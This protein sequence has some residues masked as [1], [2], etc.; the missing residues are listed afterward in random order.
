MEEYLRKFKPKEPRAGL[1][2]EILKRAKSDLL[3]EGKDTAK[4]SFVERIWRSRV[5]WGTVAA[6][7]LILAGT[8]F[9]VFCRSEKMFMALGGSAAA[10][11]S[12]DKELKALVEELVASLGGNGDLEVLQRRF[13]YQLREKPR[14][15]D[16]GARNQM[17]L[18]LVN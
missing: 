18:E 6:T 10:G 13:E 16:I 4:T 2:G 5:F 15:M 7:V 17:I 9:H 8:N 1:R 3:R 14:S 11:G 12:K